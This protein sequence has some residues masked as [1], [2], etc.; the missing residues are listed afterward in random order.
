MKNFKKIFFIILLTFLFSGS[1]FGF[2]KGKC[3]NELVLHQNLKAP[4][5]GERYIRNGRYHWYTRGIV[6]EAH[7]L[8]KHLN[9]LGFNAGK[10]D[11]IIGPK[12]KAAILRLQRFLGTKVD[13]YVGPKTRAL[14]NNSCG[15]L[16]DNSAKEGKEGGKTN[17]SNK[18]EKTANQSKKTG[19]DIIKI[20]HQMAIVDKI[21]V[22]GSCWDF[23]D[24]VYTKAG[25]P[26]GQRKIVFKSVKKG[27]YA[28]IDLI[29]PGDWL[30]YINYSYHMVE[31]SGL[32]I[33]WVNKD[34]K[35]AKILSYAGQNRSEPGRYRNYDLKSVYYIMRGE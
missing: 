28:N 26:R 2:E 19:K 21:I 4:K 24:K 18:E 25:Y 12:T 22:K 27:P 8:Q 32:F 11:G 29:K 35:I 1:I 20:A 3:P 17:G 23:L 30:Y 16:K 14:L 34:K 13:G 5:Y 9:R 10:V 33:E 7:I 6:K 31:H 15:N